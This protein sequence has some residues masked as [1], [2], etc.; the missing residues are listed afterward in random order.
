MGKNSGKKPWKVKGRKP[1]SKMYQDYKHQKASDGLAPSNGGH[2]GKPA[3]NQLEHEASTYAN[4]AAMNAARN[5]AARANRGTQGGRK[6][7]SA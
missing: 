1:V 4:R 2:L 6:P 5:K 3:S 7:F